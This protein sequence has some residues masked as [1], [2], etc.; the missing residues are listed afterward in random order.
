M[1]HSID[2]DLLRQLPTVHAVAL[3]LQRSGESPATIA[4]AL[5]IGVV[6]VPGLLE[7]AERKLAALPM[8]DHGWG[9][10]A[11]QRPG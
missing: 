8:S 6:D 11:R 4:V 1:D 2:D 7:L 10:P 5:G 9:Q 3:R